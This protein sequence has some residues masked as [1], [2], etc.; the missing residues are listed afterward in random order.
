MQANFYGRIPKDL[1]DE[2]RNNN[3]IVQIITE[4]GVPL[5]QRGQNYFARCPFHE[6]NNPSFCVSPEKQSF[7]CYGCNTGGNVF[8]FLMKSEGMTFYEAVKILAE[9]AG[10]TL[11][12][13]T[14]SQKTQS[15]IATLKELHQFALDYFHKQL[16]NPR[17]GGNA[18]TY[19]KD[20]GI[21][22]QTIM[23]FKL[24]YATASWNDFLKAGVRKG[25]SQQ[26]M[27]D[28]GLI[29]SKEGKPYDTFRERILFPIFSTY[30]E[31]VGFGGR[32]L[33]ND[34]KVPK[35]LNSPETLLY[36]KGKVLYNLNFARAA[37]Q[38]SRQAIL[39][40]GYFGAVVPYQSG[41]QNIVASLGTA[42][43]EDHARLIKQFADETVILYD[44]DAA[45]LNATQRG[46]NLL[47]KEGLRV[48]VASLP[49]GS[50]P[51]DFIREYGV[52]D[53]HDMIAKATDIIDYYI[54]MVSQD[55]NIR[56]IE[57]KVQAANELCAVLSHVQNQ[58][59]LNEYIKRATIELEIDE[60]VLRRELR[61]HGAVAEKPSRPLI[62]HNKKESPRES[63]ERQL[64]ECLLQRPDLTA[65]AASQLNYT[66]FSS[67]TYAKI[68]QMLWQRTV[69]ED[70]INVQNLI[71]NCDD[72]K[73]RG[74]ISSFVMQNLEPS[75]VEA[76]L[77]GCIKKLRNYILR[78]EEDRIK[79]DD[80]LT[81]LK[82]LCHFRQRR[83][84]EQQM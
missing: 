75:H 46:L 35:Y 2:I 1:I 25:Y 68:A 40:E 14:P 37:I 39:V 83:K 78:D 56:T 63:L 4:R 24:G 7:F 74:I 38:K 31:P 44:S 23:T 18:L 81:L 27:L 9:R 52:D 36:H 6:D 17:V 16:L 29:K 13:Y 48:K 84:A 49:T 5:R 51:D 64:L 50:D 30:G 26:V 43:T 32:T 60:S 62:T 28:G 15:T 21:S 41:V 42:F 10:I 55:K 77:T 22:A 71:D 72:E 76:I 53:F 80:D 66:D 3:D 59:A 33:L 8:T 70:N 61:K 11:P 82:E 58:I 19:L 47:I 54:R 67:D 73:L 20:R 45:G 12:G 69:N 79:A 57:A 34:D 65:Q